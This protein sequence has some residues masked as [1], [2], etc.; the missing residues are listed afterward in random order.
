MMMRFREGDVLFREG[1]ASDFACRIVEGRVLVIKEVPGDGPGAAVELGEAGPG[2]IVGE[3]GVIERRPRSATVRA[4]GDVTVEL[5]AADRLADIVAG[6]P[7]TAR[8]MLARLSERVRSLSEEV[9]HLR[10]AADAGAEPLPAEAEPDHPSGNVPDEPDAP[11][12]AMPVA[13]EAERR[14]GRYIQ[15]ARLGLGSHAISI[16]WEGRPAMPPVWVD[17]LPFR[18]GR[19]PRDG[20]P[21][22]RERGALLLPDAPPYRLSPGHFAIDRDDRLGLVVR[23]LG[24]ELGTT[25]NGQFLGGIFAKDWLR[26]PPGESV[27]VAGGLQSPFVLRIHVTP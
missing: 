27:V 20:G 24:S 5:I 16:R 12:P 8:R 4:A 25:V 10:S 19:A 22:V 6:E 21:P 15:S 23:D 14:I 17:T 11:V 1:D 13:A 3:M 9:A 26:L 18:V 7:E 2:D